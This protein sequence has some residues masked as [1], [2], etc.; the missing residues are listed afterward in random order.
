MEI[1][2]ITELHYITPIANLASI[3]KLGILSHKRAAKVQHVSVAMEEIQE[4]R[5][6]KK[7]PGAG[8]LHDYVNLYFH[9]RNPML[10]KRRTQNQ[11]ICIL[12]VDP[13]VL[14]I[15]GVIISDRNASSDYVRFF[16]LKEGLSNLDK[17]LV[18]ARH[19]NHDSYFEKIEHASI[20]C[21]EVLVLH[22]V[23][24]KLIRG[25]YVVNAKVQ[26]QVSLLKIPLSVVI[27]NDIF[28]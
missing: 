7:I 21:A 24:A 16:S 2:E 6:Q 8:D 25:I 22:C 13:E 18:Y 9:A 28:F 4:K 3:M 19:W 20:K 27:N 12:Q 23:P 26:E 15:D 14:N 10:Y 11:E 1:S 5:R 17:D